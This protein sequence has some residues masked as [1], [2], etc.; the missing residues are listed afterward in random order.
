MLCGLEQ[1][2][3]RLRHQ[4]NHHVEV[5]AVWGFGDLVAHITIR[6]AL[7][8][9]RIADQARDM[10]LDPTCFSSFGTAGCCGNNPSSGCIETLKILQ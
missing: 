1:L 2:A 10:L 7:V 9:N 8:V 6:L 3:I 4:R 5:L